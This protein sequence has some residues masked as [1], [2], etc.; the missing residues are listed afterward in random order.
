MDGTGAQLVR[1][2]VFLGVPA[3]AW[4]TSWISLLAD[5]EPFMAV[6]CF[7]VFPVGVIWGFSV[8]LSPLFS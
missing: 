8:W 3:L 6:V 5:G 7:V 4:L 1:M 2:I